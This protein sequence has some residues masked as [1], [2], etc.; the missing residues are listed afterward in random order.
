MAGGGGGGVGC[1]P[2]G[3]ELK[4]EGSPNG[5]RSGR[6]LGY[7]T[8]GENLFLLHESGTAVALL[9]SV[10]PKTV[11]FGGCSPPHPMWE[12]YHRARG[13]RIPKCYPLVVRSI[14]RHFPSYSG[15]GGGGGYDAVR[16]Q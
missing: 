13:F 6:L 7:L 14:F 11:K 1:P 5:E 9:T 2:I 15:D 8:A 16:R 10:T 12:T 3:L 4:R